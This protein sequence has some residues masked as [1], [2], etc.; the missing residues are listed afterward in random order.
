[1]GLRDICLSP[2]IHLQ[3]LAALHC[4][5]RCAEAGASSPALSALSVGSVCFR[6][7]MA[8]RITVMHTELRLYR[9]WAQ[10]RK[11]PLQDARLGGG[12]GGS[13]S[14]RQVAQAASIPTNVTLCFRDEAT[15][16]GDMDT[17][18]AKPNTHCWCRAHNIHPNRSTW[19]YPCHE[20]ALLGGTGSFEWPSHLP[21][22][23]LLTQG[24]T[25]RTLTMVQASD[26]EDVLVKGKTL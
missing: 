5:C 4:G 25:S 18:Q 15:V 23:L 1:M 2:C 10:M 17:V 6:R 20:P 9:G 19:D 14:G 7:S 11:C 21:R 26:W 12:D 24:G 22:A 13:S 3:S 16:R 8:D